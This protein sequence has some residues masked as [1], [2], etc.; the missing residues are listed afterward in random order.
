[1]A[2]LPEELRSQFE[3][4]GWYRIPGF[5]GE[6]EIWAESLA[7]FLGREPTASERLFGVTSANGDTVVDIWWK[8]RLRLSQ[9]TA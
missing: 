9:S 5:A 4:A 3:L 6:F 2:Q 8:R 1:V 7:S